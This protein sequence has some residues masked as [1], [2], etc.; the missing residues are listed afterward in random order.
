MFIYGYGK[1]WL[2]NQDDGGGSGVG[3]AEGVFG[4]SAESQGPETQTQAGAA[5][6]QTESQGATGGDGR[7]GGTTEWTPEKI[8]E[9]IR[10]SAQ[11]GAQQ[12]GT[13]QQQ[14]PQQM[15]Q[16]E[17]NQR[18]NAF[19]P[20]EQHVQDLLEGGPK[21]V[22][23]MKAIVD[24]VVKHATTVAWYQ[25]QYAQQQIS[26][27]LTPME[28]HYQ[29]VQAEKLRGEFFTTFPDLKGQTKLLAAVKTSLDQE[30]AFQGLTKE[31]GFAKIAQRAKEIL[32][33]TSGGPNSL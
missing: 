1:R 26:E 21:A 22:S 27:K 2:F 31:Q 32:Q 11:A 13:T 10:T 33:T 5:S 20:S 16:E 15:T 18:L 12:G 24:G 25:T 7:P 19:Q 6:T 29:E 4:G 23:A 30:G 9:L 28:Q 3:A 14:P 17:I 8:T